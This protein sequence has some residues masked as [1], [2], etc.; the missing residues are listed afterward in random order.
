MSPSSIRLLNS[1]DSQTYRDFRLLSRQTN[2]YS[3]ISTLDHDSRLSLQ[4]FQQTITSATKPPIYG[5][6]GVFKQH[7]L[8]SHLQLSPSYLPKQNHLVYIYEIYTHP[9]HRH[10][11]HAKTLITHAISLVSNQSHLEQLHLKVNSSNQPAIQL[12]QSLGFKHI[13]TKPQA[14]K[15]SPHK[16]QDE[17]I[18][19]LHLQT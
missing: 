11:G 4:H 9:K 6:Y 15:E 2:P 16:Y 1:D 10:Q 18:F 12:Y 13:A 3:F 14:I 7:Q 5:I 8:I 17:F 19:C